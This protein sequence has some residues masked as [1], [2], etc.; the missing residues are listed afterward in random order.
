MEITRPDV[1]PDRTGDPVGL[2]SSINRW[3]TMIRL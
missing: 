1:E 3:V 2:A